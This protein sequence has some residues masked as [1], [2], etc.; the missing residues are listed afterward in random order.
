[1]FFY[2]TFIQHYSEILYLEYNG[3]LHYNLQS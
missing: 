3:G 1:M 2:M